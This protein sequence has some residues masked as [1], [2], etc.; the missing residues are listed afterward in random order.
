M[1]IRI[2]LLAFVVALSGCRTKDAPNSLSPADIDVDKKAVIQVMRDW[3]DGYLMHDPARLDRVRDDDWTYSGD[4]SGVVVA[5]READKIFQTDTTRYL[6]F[7][8]DDVNAR[9]YGATA[10]LTGREKLRWEN[11]GKTDS[12]SY[13]ITAVFV[14][15]GTQWRCVASHSSPITSG[16]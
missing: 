16:H 12:A 7:D 6:S 9:I 5:K 13:R 11:G 10:V 15:R 8:Y 3:A 2:T 1:R 4:P 14:K